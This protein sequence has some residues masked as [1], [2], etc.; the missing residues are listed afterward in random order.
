MMG[1]RDE[2]EDMLQVSFVDVYKHLASYRYAST[3]G[4]WIKRIVINN[5]ISTLKKRRLDMES[6]D[7]GHIQ[8][9]DT[10]YSSEEESNLTVEAVKEA[11]KKLPEGYRTVF[12]LY[13]FE[14]YDHQEIGQILSVSEATSK[15][16]YSRAKK[17]MR[18]LLQTIV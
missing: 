7:D 2:A 15:S 13:V 3:L 18:E 8:I 1:S 9:A 12:S 14:G 10:S 4:S 5:C 11:L 16:Q 6:I 17:R